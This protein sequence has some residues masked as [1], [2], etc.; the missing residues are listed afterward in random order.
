MLQRGNLV[1]STLRSRG[2]FGD[3]RLAPLYRNLR[4]A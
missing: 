2:W 3:A 1:A 4:E